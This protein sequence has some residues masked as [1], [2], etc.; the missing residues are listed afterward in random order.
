MFTALPEHILPWQKVLVTVW[1]NIRLLDAVTKKRQL[2]KSCA[3]MPFSA[4]KQAR[5]LFSERHIYLWSS[6]L[7]GFG[8]NSN[9]SQDL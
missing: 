3:D 6:G 5:S 8:T 7:R 2:E 1:A 4:N 9:V